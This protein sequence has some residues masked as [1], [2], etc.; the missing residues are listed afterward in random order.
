MEFLEA[1]Q[2]H[3]KYRVWGT[4]HSLRIEISIPDDRFPGGVRESELDPSSRNT[5]RVAGKAS[6]EDHQI[7]SPCLHD[8]LCTAGHESDGSP[9]KR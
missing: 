1:N 6:L 8:K 5:P 4:R 2:R 7:L 3:R 9:P